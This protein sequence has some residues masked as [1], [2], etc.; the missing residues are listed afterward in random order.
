MRLWTM[1]ANTEERGDIGL[2]VPAE[3]ERMAVL[4]VGE[5]VCEQGLTLHKISVCDSVVVNKQK[6]ARLL[7]EVA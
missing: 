4:M 2:V 5:M 7:K 1:K 6:F 3:T